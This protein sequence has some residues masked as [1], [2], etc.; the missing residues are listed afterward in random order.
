MRKSVRPIL[1][2]LFILNALNLTS[3]FA[4]DRAGNG[5]GGIVRN[6]QYLTFGSANVRLRP[7]SLQDIPGLNRLKETI[8]NMPLAPGRR[9]AL[10]S[11]AYPAGNR[12]YFAISK[13]ELGP[14]QEAELLMK[15][16]DATGYEIPI[17]SLVV[18]AVTSGTETYLLPSFFD[19][20]EVEQA[21]ILFHEALWIIN[22]S[23][24]Y[25]EVIDAEIAFQN[26]LDE[27]GTGFKAQLFRILNDVFRDR[28]ISVMA[29]AQDDFA[30]N[31]FNSYFGRDGMT[32]ESIFGRELMIV[33][34]P[35][36]AIF[37]LNESPNR[38]L[39]ALHLMALIERFPE[40]NTFKEF[41]ALRDRLSPSLTWEAGGCVFSKMDRVKFWKVEYWQEPEPGWGFI[42]QNG[43]RF[44]WS[45]SDDHYHY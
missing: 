35:R 42:S 23:L 9:G 33:D 29:A 37:H 2:I 30:H 43:C 6:G 25:N 41:Y 34:H 31:R 36:E 13:E 24:T 1:G 38:D 39:L 3:G 19:I 32:V 22:S 26:Y 40:V 45:N 27:G 8:Q 16:L 12:Q 21:A 7:V 20:T 28:T 4:A 14:E 18:F 17:T 11:A 15:Y 44:F 10:V 5:G